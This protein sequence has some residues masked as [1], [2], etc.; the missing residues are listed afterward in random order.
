MLTILEGS[1][2]CICDEQG[3]IGG[4]TGGL[5]A[6]DTRYLSRLELIVDGKR[7]L[8]LSSGRVE[9]FSAAFFLRNDVTA[10]LGQDVVSIDRRRFVGAAGMTDTFLVRNEGMET[11]AFRLSIVVEADFADILTVKERDFTLGAP[12]D[13]AGPAADSRCR[14]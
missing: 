9:Y 1:T 4:G 10:S 13:G 6:E 3:D 12:G 14:A 8:I 11:V 7:P 2:F 5:F